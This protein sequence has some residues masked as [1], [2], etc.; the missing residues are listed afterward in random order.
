[1]MMESES[2]RAASTSGSRSTPESNRSESMPGSGSNTEKTTH[3]L[4]KWRRRAL[5]YASLFRVAVAIVIVSCDGPSGPRTGSITLTVTGLPA[6]IPAAVTITTPEKT[7]LS[8]TESRQFDNLDPGV[9]QVTA[10]QAVS[11]KSTFGVVAVTSVVEVF[12]GTTPTQASVTYTVTTGILALSLVGVPAGVTPSV[13]L[14]NAS[15]Y[16][17]TLNASGEVGNLAPGAYT[18]TAA[19]FEGG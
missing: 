16:S 13:Q 5:Q 14:S 11:E 7:I 4:L 2:T 19:D 18:V 17:R 1:M 3:L 8:A 15:G 10:T 9:Y 6:G 12:A